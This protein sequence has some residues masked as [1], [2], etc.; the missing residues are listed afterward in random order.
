MSLAT[1][2]SAAPE[3]VAIVGTG[4]V[5]SALG[6]RLARAGLSVTFLARE[7]SSDASRDLIV[8]AGENARVAPVPGG[9]VG[10][11]AVFLAVPA[12]VAVEAART[13]GASIDSVIVDCTNPVRWDAGPVWAPPVE[14][15]TAAAIAKAL[16]G[17][18]VVK[19]FNTFGAEWHAEPAASDGPVT[20][21]MAGD[22]DEAK[23]TVAAIARRAGFDPVDA[24][25]LRNAALLENLATLW[26]HLATTGGLGRE[27]AFRLTRR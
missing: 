16:D 17:H 9:A 12:N 18:A 10:A 24:G 23:A 13:A 5:G 8:G 11:D 26:I 7:P 21:P 4:N 14:G 1:E 2:S 22:Q 25:P 19:A 15:S 27:I 20:V 3:R 6:V